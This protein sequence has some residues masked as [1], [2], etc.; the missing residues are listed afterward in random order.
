MISGSHALG[1]LDFW[2]EPPTDACGAQPAWSSRTASVVSLSVSH[3]DVIPSGWVWAPSSAHTPGFSGRDLRYHLQ[4]PGPPQAPRSPRIGPC[5]FLTS[6]TGQRS[7]WPDSCNPT[8][9]PQVPH[10]TDEGPRA[11]LT[12]ASRGFLGKRPAPS[13]PSRVA[14]GSGCFGKQRTSCGP[15]W[16]QAGARGS[17][18]PG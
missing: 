18:Q 12:D 9:S 10:P 11:G 2:R 7:W 4:N 13:V 8:D 17:C 6:S 3:L 16:G 14:L 1:A 5:Q 15:L